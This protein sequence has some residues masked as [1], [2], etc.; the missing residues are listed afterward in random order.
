MSRHATRA[1]LVVVCASVL[2]APPAMAERRPHTATRVDD[3]AGDTTTSTTAPPP[4]SST[5]STTA[6]SGTSTST[7]STTVSPTDPGAGGDVTGGVV[8]DVDVSVPPPGD[9]DGTHVPSVAIV[10][11]L[12]SARALLDEAVARADAARQRVDDLHR[13]L[14]DVDARI[15]A[16]TDEERQAVKRV[17][18]SQ[19]VLAE[20]AVD[21]YI[22]G[23][24]GDL[25]ATLTAEDPNE[26]SRN[27]AMMESVLDADHD[28][29]G[30]YRSARREVSG[31]LVEL[32]EQRVEVAGDLVQAKDWD[33]AMRAEVRDARVQ[34]LAFEAGSEIFVT[35]MHFPVD[36][37]H[38][39]I[40]SW[41][42][43]RSGGR[44][45][46][47]IDIFATAGTNLFAVERGVITNMGSNSLGGIKLWLYGESGTT[48]Y[49]A[50]LLRFAPG[51]TEGMVVEAGDVVGFVG[52]TGNAATTP[53]HLHFEIHP[54]NGPAV[55]PTPLLRVVDA[56]DD[57]SV[58]SVARR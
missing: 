35:G 42:S 20:R 23:N 16:L 55:N 5:T 21:A 34:L 24:Y 50:H 15:V 40:D 10:G 3:P 19:N 43:P 26:A 13:R 12:S 44:Q 41:L 11:D 29:V 49:Y 18:E 52:N 8:P 47:G 57:A 30:D 53:S 31:E 48:Y 14:D 51:I 46:Q 32:G 9:L 38:D 54:N 6:P 17:E 39:Y 7:T 56:L 28:A 36:D 4:P 45:H 37:P 27:E 22:R 25:A 2:L 58:A 33:K 1:L